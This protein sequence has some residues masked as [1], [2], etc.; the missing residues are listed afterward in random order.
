[1]IDKIYNFKMKYRKTCISAL[2]FL[3]VIFPNIIKYL[4]GTFKEEHNDIISK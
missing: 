4:D 3:R 1:M 2:N